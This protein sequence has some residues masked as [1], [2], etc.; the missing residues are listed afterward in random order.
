MDL[1]TVTKDVLFLSPKSWK[2]RRKKTR[3]ERVLEE[4]KFGKRHKLTDLRS[5]PNS[6][7]DKPQRN[8]HHGT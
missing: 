3:G 5:R 8:S 2:E 4:I 7:K 1:W 6:Q